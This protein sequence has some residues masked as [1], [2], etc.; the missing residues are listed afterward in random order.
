M[1]HHRQWRRE[2]GRNE[3]TRREDQEEATAAAVII[4]LVTDVSGSDMTCI[5]RE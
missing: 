4:A 2:R 5:T 3:D 1:D